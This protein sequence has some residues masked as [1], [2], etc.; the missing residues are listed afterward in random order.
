LRTRIKFCGITRAEDIAAAVALGVDALGLIL[1][2]RSPRAL[3]LR[4]AASLRAQIPPLVACV[5]LLRDP[6]P[7]LVRAVVRQLRPDLLQFH[8]NEAAALC[9]RAGRPYVKAIPMGEPA[10]G[11]AMLDAHAAAAGFVFDSH[12]AAGLG[13]SG[14]VFDWTQIPA[15]ARARAILAGGLDPLT[16]IEAVRAVRPY[17]VDVSSG[18]ESAPGIKCPQRMRDFV[19]A[20]R[21]ADATD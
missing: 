16:V 1:V 9:R 4:Q 8:G 18:I 20:V 14:K 21:A 13:G 6:D 15:A 11:L 12:R 7:A 19:A 3:T 2:E 17:A 10:A 5:V